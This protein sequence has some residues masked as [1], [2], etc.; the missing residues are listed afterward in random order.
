MGATLGGGAI[1]WSSA[2][3]AFYP[4]DTEIAGYSS[5]PANA[6]Y[7]A[8]TPSD[9]YSHL[10]GDTTPSTLQATLTPSPA[11]SPTAS[12]GTGVVLSDGTY[13]YV[14]ARSSNPGP[15]VWTKIGTGHN[16]TLGHNYGPIGPDLSAQGGVARSGF[17]LSG[18]LYNGY[19]T[20]VSP[21]TF[22]GVKTADGSTDSS[23]SPAAPRHP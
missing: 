11:P 10:S 20:S 3:S 21:V 17:L 15:T 22:D 14:H 18:Y 19:A 2:G 13:L 5:A 23:A 9:G 1:L 12:P 8:T 4:G 6:F 16:S 7:R